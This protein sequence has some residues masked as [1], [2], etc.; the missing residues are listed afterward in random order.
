MILVLSGNQQT[1]KMKIKLKVNLS[2]ELILDIERS[3]TNTGNKPEVSKT[4]QLTSDPLLLSDLSGWIGAVT[5]RAI[6]HELGVNEHHVFKWKPE[7]KYFQY[8]I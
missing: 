5:V 7:N 3:G 6:L 2:R 4:F 1:N 8:L